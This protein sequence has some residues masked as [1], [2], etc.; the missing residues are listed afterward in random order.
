MIFIVLKRGFLMTV[1]II[2]LWQLSPPHATLV[3]FAGPLIT[4][5]LL[6][7]ADIH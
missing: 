6:L 3:A 2:T 1:I 4:I 5:C 7:S